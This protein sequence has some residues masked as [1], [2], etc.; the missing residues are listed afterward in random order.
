MDL[1]VFKAPSKN[2]TKKLKICT[3]SRAEKS[4]KTIIIKQITTKE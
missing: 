2:T 3:I 1:E 4:T